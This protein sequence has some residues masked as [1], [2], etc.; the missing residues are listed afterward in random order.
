MQVN[1]DGMEAD[2][3]KGME[4]LKKYME[5]LKEGGTELLQERP[6]NDEKVVK[7]THDEEK[8]NVN[9]DFIESNI[10]L[11]T[12]HIS[13]IDMTKFDGKDLITWML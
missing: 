11:M 13:K 4:Y 8:L 7:E 10:W 9:N 6:P 5:G 3:E 12:H 1:I 2:L